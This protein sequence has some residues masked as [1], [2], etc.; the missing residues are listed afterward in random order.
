M[1]HNCGFGFYPVVPDISRGLY[2]IRVSDCNLYKCAI[3][4]ENPKA[5]FNL[6]EHSMRWILVVMRQ[7]RELTDNWEFSSE[8]L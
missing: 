1:L 8:L 3:K 5:Y 6:Q 7:L 4:Y 2:V